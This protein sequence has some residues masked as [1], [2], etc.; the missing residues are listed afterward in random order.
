MEPLISIVSLTYN[1]EKFIR[2]TLD[3]FLMQETDFSFEIVIH[4]DAS[5]DNTQSIIREYEVRFPHIIKPIFQ[6]ENQKSKGNGIVTQIAF[7]AARGKYIAIC[8]GDDF[9]TDSFKLQKQ[10]DFL[11]A[12]P[13]T[14]FCFHNVD[15][16]DQNNTL[17]FSATRMNSPILYSWQDIFHIYIPPLSVVFRNIP[18]QY[19]PET[20]QILNGDILLFALL[21]SYGG[22]ANLGFVGACYRKHSGGIYSGDSQ[23]GKYVNSV[24]SRRVM[25]RS[26]VFNANQK[27][28]IAKE[29]K[30]KKHKYLKRLIK[31]GRIV[32]FFRLSIA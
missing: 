21:T 2:Q 17:L 23:I 25:L 28:E 24:R 5:T 30:I 26:A 14:S 12:N 27:K 32:D 16:V 11:E 8:E 9:W 1:H 31:S 6:K 15:V 19:P 22:G 13:N 7:G 4:D 29:I 20:K 18:L 3:G 10:V